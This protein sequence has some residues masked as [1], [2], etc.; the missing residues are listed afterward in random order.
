ML[1]PFTRFSIILSHERFFGLRV[2][3]HQIWESCVDGRDSHRNIVSPFQQT[4]SAAGTKIIQISF[5]SF[6]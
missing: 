5:C 3:H 6:Q 2:F 4:Y 1:A